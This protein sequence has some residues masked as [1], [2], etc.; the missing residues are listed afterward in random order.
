MDKRRGLL[1]GMR[2]T[3]SAEASGCPARRRLVPSLSGRTRIRRD[4]SLLWLEIWSLRIH[5]G[6]RR[7]CRGIGDWRRWKIVGKRCYGRNERP[8]V[9]GNRFLL[10]GRHD[11]SI[12]GRVGGCAVCIARYTAAWARFYLRTRLGFCRKFFV[13]A[14]VRR[15]QRRGSGACRGGL[16]GCLRQAGLS[17]F[18]GRGLFAGSPGFAGFRSGEGEFRH[19]GGILE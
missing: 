17:A 5:G 9:R 10:R 12:A 15:L 4:V 11:G 2:R 7:V 19:R 18:D 6:K 8:A 16:R 1:S 3:H 14:W 13:L